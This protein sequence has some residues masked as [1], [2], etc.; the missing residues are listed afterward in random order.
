MYLM[1]ILMY[2]ILHIFD[3]QVKLVIHKNRGKRLYEIDKSGR[4]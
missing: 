3:S 2:M 1:Y 4:F